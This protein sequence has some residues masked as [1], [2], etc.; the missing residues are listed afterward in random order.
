MEFGRVL[1]LSLAIQISGF[2]EQKPVFHKDSTVQKDIQKSNMWQLS[3]LIGCVIEQENV[4]ALEENSTKSYN[5]LYFSLIFI[6]NSF[7]FA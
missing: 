4:I 5:F 2:I 6:E 3:H 7:F 1:T